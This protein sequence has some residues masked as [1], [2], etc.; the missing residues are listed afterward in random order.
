MP[1]S[2]ALDVPL[3][4]DDNAIDTF[5]N[6]MRDRM[7]AYVAPIRG[8]W[9]VTVSYCAFRRSFTKPSMVIEDLPA[10]NVVH[11]WLHLPRDAD[12]AR[13]CAPKRRNAHGQLE[14]IG[15]QTR[16]LAHLDGFTRPNEAGRGRPWEV[17][18]APADFVLGLA[19]AVVGLQLLVLQVEGAW[20]MTQHRSK[21][22]RLET[23][24]G[25]EA[26]PHG[27]PAYRHET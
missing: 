26:D 14:A 20:E 16:L 15:N 17:S 19:R 23:I 10:E 2:H 12:E 24:G 13:D 3:H 5:A 9:R 27:R 4:S 8:R 7:L 11:G 25:H 6:A 18:D 22:D 21:G 1:H